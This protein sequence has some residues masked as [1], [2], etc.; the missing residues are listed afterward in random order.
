MGFANT[1][2]DKG[3]DFEIRHNGSLSIDHVTSFPACLPLL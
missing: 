2:D 3:N 1:A